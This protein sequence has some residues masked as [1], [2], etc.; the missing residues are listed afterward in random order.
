MY[1]CK[2][3][4]QNAIAPKSLFDRRGAVELYVIAN[5][6]IYVETKS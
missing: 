1:L 4:C 3:N 6:M 5:N 2:L